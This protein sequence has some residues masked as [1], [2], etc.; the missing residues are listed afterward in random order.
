[1]V[2][3]ELLHHTI[4]A[5]KYLLKIPVLKE[6]LEVAGIAKTIIGIGNHPKKELSRPAV[7]FLFIND[8]NSRPNVLPKRFETR[9][10]LTLDNAYICQS[11]HKH[12][13]TFTQFSLF[14]CT[15]TYQI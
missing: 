1:M 2:A 13:Y 3:V 6:K 4:P 10:F 7:T 15:D 12:S 9:Y 5:E 8:F 11:R 14:P